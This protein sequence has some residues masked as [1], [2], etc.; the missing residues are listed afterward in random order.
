MKPFLTEPTILK[1]LEL[2]ILKCFATGRN[3]EKTFGQD[4]WPTRWTQETA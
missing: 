2:L 3:L 1:M 4:G